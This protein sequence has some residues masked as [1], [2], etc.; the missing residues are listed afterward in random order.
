MPLIGYGLF[1]TGQVAQHPKEEACRLGTGA[2]GKEFD[3]KIVCRCALKEFGLPL[4][5]Q[6]FDSFYDD[7]LGHALKFCKI[8]NP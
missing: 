4:L 8:H 6:Y 7:L 2:L 5:L 3:A 1:V